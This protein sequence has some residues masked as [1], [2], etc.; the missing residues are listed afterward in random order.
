MRT[1]ATRTP[2]IN[3][4]EFHTGGSPARQ[5]CPRL[6]GS[7]QTTD[8]I[9]HYTLRGTEGIS[10]LRIQIHTDSY[11]AQAWGRVDRWSTTAGEWR[12][13]ATIGGSA[14]ATDLKI[15]YNRTRAAHDYQADRDRLILLAEEVLA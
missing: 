4:R 9:E 6:E 11:K 13:V 10:K 7:G 14:L 12:E 5:A 8:Y 15:G 2:K 1:I 3:D